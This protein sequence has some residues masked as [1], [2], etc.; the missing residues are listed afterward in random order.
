MALDTDASGGVPVCP[1]LQ[2][3]ELTHGKLAFRSQGERKAIVFLHG[4]LGSSKS[5]AFQLEHFSRRYQAIA[6]DAPGFGESEMVPESIDAYVEV[7]REFLAKLDKSMV[8]LVGHSMGGTVASRFAAKYPQTV[9]RLVL[10]CT[11]PGYALPESVPMPPKFLNRMRELAE[12]GPQA[13]GIKRA[14]DLLPTPC[15]A[16]VFNYAAQVASETKPEGLR[17]ATRMLQ[18]ADNRPLLP[19]LK[20]PVLVL[21]GAIDTVVQPALNADLLRLTPFTRHVEMPGIAHA[22]YFQEPLYY[23]GLIETFLSEK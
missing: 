15:S 23:N 1:P 13:Y 14:T 18:L 22:P 21:T 11:H 12:I 6:W 19:T 3:A 20:M 8:F 10:S 5:W 2:I 7:L 9:S 17:R 16:E 4:L